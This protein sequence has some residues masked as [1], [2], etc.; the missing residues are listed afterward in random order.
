MRKK[1]NISPLV[2]A[3]VRP[4]RIA[5][6]GLPVEFGT[7]RPGRGR[8]MGMRTASPPTPP[9]IG[10]EADPK[11]TKLRQTL[12]AVRSASVA[13]GQIHRLLRDLEKTLRRAKESHRKSPAGTKTLQDRID[14]TMQAVDAVLLG[15]GDD[16]A[17]IRAD[18]HKSLNLASIAEVHAIVEQAVSQVR[19]KH[20]DLEA[21]LAGRLEPACGEAD[22]TAENRNAA[23]TATHDFDFS[24]TVGCMTG[25]DLLLHVLNFRAE[26]RVKDE[27]S[28]PIL[29]LATGAR[30]ADS[31]SDGRPATRVPEFAPR[32]PVP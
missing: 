5:P 9:P 1:T 14:S 18:G 29:R 13:L 15:A 24:D 10:N 8:A 26:R 21:F 12:Q 19:V 23:H 25:G 30:R 28:S 2:S 32:A 3:R 6:N 20:S 11:A 31:P 17:D 16:L 4:I 7:A 27:D 22:V